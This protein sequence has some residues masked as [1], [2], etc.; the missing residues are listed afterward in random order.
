MP[1]CLFCLR[2][3]EGDTVRFTDEHVFPAALGGNV[4]VKDGSCDGCN[5]GNS[6]FEQ[7]L[8]VELTPIRMLLQIPDRYGN[9]PH[10]AATIVT[11]EKTYDGRVK[12]DGS[13]MVKPVVTQEKNEKGECEFVHR[14]LTDAQKEKLRGGRFRPLGARSSHERWRSRNESLH[15]YCGRERP[16]ASPAE[17]ATPSGLNETAEGAN[18]RG[19]NSL[20]LSALARETPWL[21]CDWPLFAAVRAVEISHWARAKPGLQ[22]QLPPRER[23]R[24]L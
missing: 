2:E 8:A 11:P 14:F 9:V 21:V 24:P 23:R 13:V 19:S 5:H 6:K 16:V 10:T 18:P 22:V 4:I 7:A 15:H 1:Q 12:G 20:S 17:A 3:G